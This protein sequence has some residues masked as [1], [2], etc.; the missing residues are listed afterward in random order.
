[1]QYMLLIY[2]SEDITPKPGTEEF[3]PF[4]QG[5]MEM[6]NAAREAGVLVNGDAL[7]DVATATTVSVRNGKTHVT[8]GPFAETKEQLGGYYV[9]DCKNLDEAIKYAA[10]IPSSQHGRVEIRPV[11]TFD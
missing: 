7:Q 10:M 11:E 2:S 6:T 1:M 8:D 3:G 5:Y 9:L 4:M